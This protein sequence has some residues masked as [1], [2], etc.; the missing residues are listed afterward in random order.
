[1]STSTSQARE[2]LPA[3]PF[4]RLAA[5]VYD[6]LLL[7]AVLFLATLVL[8]PL[9]RGEAILVRGSGIAGAGF[10]AFVALLIL[11][12]FGFSWTRRGQTLGMMSWRIRLERQGG[13]HIGWAWSALRVLIGYGIVA[14]A[15][16]G[17]W[18]ASG[19]G[20]GAGGV[21]PLLLL[22]PALANYVWMAF[23][24]QSRTLQDVLTRCRVVRLP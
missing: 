11:G 1:M 17:L 7:I 14:A 19:P 23:D 4:R 5:L 10:S 6:S 12:F 16:A 24:G 9:T 13:R 15:C 18:L 2:R 8:L 3:G 20:G 21:L 22:A